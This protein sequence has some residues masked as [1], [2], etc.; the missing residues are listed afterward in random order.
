MTSSQLQRLT[1]E[2]DVDGELLEGDLILR[3][4][5][6]VKLFSKLPVCT[7][8]CRSGAGAEL[9]DKHQVKAG[10]DAIS[11]T[12]TYPSGNVLYEFVVALT[13]CNRSHSNDG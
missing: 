9:A 11:S 4:G 5:K 2:W 7:I 13:L 10:G 8:S 1:A 6:T 3:R 12:G